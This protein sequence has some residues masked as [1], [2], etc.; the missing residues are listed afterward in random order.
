M[1]ELETFN[2]VLDMLRAIITAQDKLNDE[3][4]AQQKQRLRE[5]I[6]E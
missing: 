3:T 1:L 2:E 4:K 6:E 5:L